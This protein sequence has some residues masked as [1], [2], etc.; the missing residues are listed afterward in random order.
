MGK[1]RA[2]P[3]SRKDIRQMAHTMRGLLGIKQQAYVDVINLLENVLPLL[4][5][6]FSYEYVPDNEMEV[7]GLTTPDNSKITIR[8]SVYIGACRG[9]GRDRF[10]IMHEIAHFFLHKGLAV[11]LTRGNETVKTFED[12]EWQADA[13][14]GEFLMDCDVVEGMSIEEISSRCGVSLSAAKCQ[15]KQYQK[16]KKTGY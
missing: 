10:T 11:Q 1:Y 9:N 8:E 4:Y 14:A 5:E 13:F 12:P 16:N 15:H 7:M 3:L 6:N 2:R